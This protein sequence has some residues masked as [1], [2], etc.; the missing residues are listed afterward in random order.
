MA[1]LYGADQSH[2]GLEEENSEIE[3]RLVSP[4]GTPSF[5]SSE[6]PSRTGGFNTNAT[7]PSSVPKSV[8]SRR[9]PLHIE[10]RTTRPSSRMATPVASHSR[11]SNG[12]GSRLHSNYENDDSIPN[13]ERLGGGGGRDIR[14]SHTSRKHLM[15]GT[16]TG[17]GANGSPSPHYHHSMV[18]RDDRLDHERLQLHSAPSLPRS[19]ER[20][21]SPKLRPK[22]VKGGH[23][24]E[25]SPFSLGDYRNQRL[26]M[27]EEDK[28]NREK[29]YNAT[30]NSLNKL[31]LNITNELI[32]SVIKPEI[33]VET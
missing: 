19:L 32:D 9:T 10:G 4:F 16:G 31:Q 18:M 2:P 17:G 12:G 22:W 1:C 7:R 28:N 13:Q 3:T 14:T 8:S 27:L 30:V 20:R 21:P 15:S 24:M 23:F 29:L 25:P 5:I 11:S 33:E 6:S 26:L